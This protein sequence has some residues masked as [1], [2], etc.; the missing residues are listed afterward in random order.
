MKKVED[1]H[2][3][4]SAWYLK[5]DNEVVSGLIKCGLRRRNACA[6]KFHL[7]VFSISNVRC[8]DWD[9]SVC[10]AQI[11]Y[12]FWDD[13]DWAILVESATNRASGYPLEY[14][15]L[16][17]LEAGAAA[18]EVVYHGEVG[19]EDNLV[20]SAVNCSWCTRRSTLG[21]DK[22]RTVVQ[23]GAVRGSSV[24]KGNGHL[25]LNGT[26]VLAKN[27]KYTCAGKHKLVSLP[28][29]SCI[30]EAESGCTGLRVKL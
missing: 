3:A 13:S 5:W 22:D 25:L 9:T 2:V 18:D 4:V 23:S 26:H 1:I 21:I 27:W 15:R 14:G 10:G 20:F 19:Q 11:E 17:N 29:W 28:D 7:N 24:N 6:R 30:A 8:L 12:R 16:Q